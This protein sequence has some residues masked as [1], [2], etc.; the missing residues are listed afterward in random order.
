MEVL[1]TFKIQIEKQNSE[2]GYS[3]TSVNIQIK[4]KMPQPSQEH[5]V[6]FKA[7]NQDLKEM[8]VLCTFK[9]KVESPNLE[10]GCIKEQ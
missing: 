10:N 8:D 1:C 5:Q 3:K 6:F 2:H 9:I 7:P 4:I